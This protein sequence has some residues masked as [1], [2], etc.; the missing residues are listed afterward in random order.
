M[1][2][3]RRGVQPLRVRAQEVAQSIR[4]LVSFCLAASA[5]ILIFGLLKS[6][7]LDDLWSP[8]LADQAKLLLA[9][10]AGVIVVARIRYRRRRGW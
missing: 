7:A 6:D 9:G 8:A 3:A 2:A 1:P 4:L 5:I 10:A